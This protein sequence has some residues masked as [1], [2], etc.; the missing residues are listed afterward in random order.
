MKAAPGSSIVARIRPLY[1]S[2]GRSGRLCSLAHA[3]TTP[4]QSEKAS[5]PFVMHWAAAAKAANSAA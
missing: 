1:L 4:P 2:R 5:V 3:L